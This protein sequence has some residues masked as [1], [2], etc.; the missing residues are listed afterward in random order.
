MIKKE[1]IVA[2]VSIVLLAFALSTLSNMNAIV[3]GDKD[4]E[5][6]KD[7]LWG[8]IR[9]LQS[10]VEALEARIEALETIITIKIEAYPT[11]DFYL[12]YHGLSIDEPL[13]DMWWL[14]DDYNIKTTGS[15]FTYEK[16]VV[17]ER[18][19]HYVEYAASGYPPDYAWHARIYINDVLKAEG[20]VGRHYHLRADFDV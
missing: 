5:N 6:F 13:P 11:T 20:D 12:R 7:E 10:E 18:G 14:Y 1:Q 16:T 3:S 2:T 19:S 4:E 15:T 17:L 8:A 9:E